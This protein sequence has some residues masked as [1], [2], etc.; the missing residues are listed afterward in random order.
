MGS[1]S[2]MWASRPR[3]TSSGLVSCC[4]CSGTLVKAAGPCVGWCRLT[5]KTVRGLSMDGTLGRR[6]YRHTGVVRARHT[7][8]FLSPDMLAH[9]RDHCPPPAKQS[10]A[11]TGDA[12][13]LL[14]QGWS[15][16]WNWSG[17][18]GPLVLVPASSQSHSASRTCHPPSLNFSFCNLDMSVLVCARYKAYQL[19]GGVL[20]VYCHLRTIWL[21]FMGRE[22]QT[23][24][25]FLVSDS[26]TTNPC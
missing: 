23:E 3:P 11:L 26:H 4:S 10:Q 15:E 22:G 2:W 9:L 8:D 20:V 18:S 19:G 12:V 7:S 1:R 16:G 13:I 17:R 14:K 5:R 21:C 24:Y 25:T 6:E